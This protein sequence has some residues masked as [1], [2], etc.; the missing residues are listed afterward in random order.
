MHYFDHSATTPIHPEVLQL[1]QDTEK[2]HF[3]N[4]SSIHGLG[5]KARVLIEY[6]RRQAAQAIGA[7][8]SEIIF[9]GGG[10]EANNL[11][12]WNLLNSSK[13]HVVTSSIEHPSILMVLD[14]LKSLGISYTPVEV[15]SNGRIK[16]DSVLNAIRNDTGLVSIMLANNEVG[17]IQPVEELGRELEQQNIPFHSDA[18]QTLGKIP[19]DVNKLKTSMLSFSGHKFYGPKGCGFLFLKKGIKLK[20]LITGGGQEHNLRAGTEN[21][22]A[23]AGLGL[24]AELAVKSLSATANHLSALEAEFK[25]EL[26][27][28]CAN[29]IFNGDPNHHLPGLINVSFP[30]QTSD[31]LLA[32]LDRKGM[33]V[34]S[35]SACTAGAVKPSKVL[36][37]MQIPKEMNLASLR[38]SFGK[39]NS[40]E[41]IKTLVKT[42]KEI[43]A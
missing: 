9:T 2:N 38:F 24:A 5:R 25:A 40:H 30:G 3:G 22:S 12:L 18:V 37:S 14:R 41:E 10:S 13:K 20:S 11:V 4:P 15:D 39:S 26:K 28:A 36:E 33:A 6:S 17:T 7:N 19:L 31:I 34:S 42:L 8:S 27:K 43:T 21:V 1:L 29:V 32:L 35:G 16:V 23:I